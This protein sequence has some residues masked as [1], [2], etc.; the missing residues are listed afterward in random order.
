MENL[1]KIFIISGLFMYFFSCGNK[2]TVKQDEKEKRWEL[3]WSDEFNYEGLLDENKWDYDGGGG[4]WGNAEQQFYTAY[5]T[6]TARVSNGVLVIE[7]HKKWHLGMPYKSARVVTRGK[8][9]FL[10]GRVEVRAKLPK[11]RG[12]W[13]AIWMMPSEQK[14]GGWP[15][16]GEIDIMEMVGHEQDVIHMSIHTESFNHKIGTHKTFYTFLQGASDDFHIYGVEWYSDRIDF[17]I[18]ENKYFT[19]KKIADNYKVWPFDQKFYL[20]MNI[21]IGGTWGGAKGIDNSIFPQRMEV[22]YVRIYKLA[23]Q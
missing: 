18:D 2:S 21:A 3:V 5:D 1:L 15:S 11:G 17:F 20:I 10:Y 22:D 9:D 13:P 23:G 4:G 8:F 19:F 7:A 12:V 16:S 14:Y 6:E